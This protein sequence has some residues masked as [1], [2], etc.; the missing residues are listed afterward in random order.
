MKERPR[1][2]ERLRKI[3]AEGLVERKLRGSRERRFT[4]GSERVCYVR[5]FTY[6]ARSS[7]YLANENES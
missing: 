5:M 6:F 1:E 7:F 4:F 2:T 3:S